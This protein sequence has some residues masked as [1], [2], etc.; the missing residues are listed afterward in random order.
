M[1]VDIQKAINWIEGNLEDEIS[2]QEISEYIGYSKYHTSRK[3][4]QYTG[5]SLQRYITL[6]R[7]STAAKE[8]RD[9]QVRII[10]I[11]IKYGYNSQE[12]FTRSFY[13]AFGI[14]PGEYQKTKKAI[15]YILKKD[16]LFPHHL[17]Q[18]GEVIR[19]KDQ[20]ILV[21]LVTVPKHQF[22]YLERAQVDN[23]MD[24]WEKVD[25]EEGMDC[26]YLHGLLASIQGVYDEGYGAFTN[27]GYIFGKD[28]PLDFTLEAKYGF[29]TKVIEEQQYLQFEHPGFSEAEFGAA[30]EQVRKTALQDFDFD[31][32]GYEVDQSF[33]NA[34]EH[35]GMDACFYFIR[36]PLKSR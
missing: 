34:Y 3:F 8:L 10:D 28:A 21:K 22:I 18:K 17:P 2:L 9:H 5:S 26:D 12:A 7:L 13:S 4:K 35:S 14:N 36:I 15:P 19:V 25:Q 29:Q 23:Y 27:D 16:V 30:L 31:L 1:L 20:D 24:F 6:R 33:V 11:A 32:E